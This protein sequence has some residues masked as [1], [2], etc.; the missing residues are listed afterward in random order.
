MLF[1][2]NSFENSN[3]NFL[4]IFLTS[5]NMEFNN[6]KIGFKFTEKCSFT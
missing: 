4:L 6:L 3:P 5:L 1:L 2:I